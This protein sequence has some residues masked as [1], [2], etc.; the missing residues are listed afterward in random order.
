[1]TP[2][3]FLRTS[4]AVLTA[5][6]LSLP[7][8]AAAEIAGVSTLT[9]PAAERG[10]DLDVT[11]WYPAGSGGTATSLGDSIFFQGTESLRDA[12]VAE[13][14]FPLILLSHGAGLGGRPEAAAWLAA[15]L[16]AR[17]FVVAAPRHPGNTGPD[18]SAA[19]TLKLWLRPA[20]L[21]ATLDAVA[22]D[23]EFGPHLDTR[24]TGVLGLSMG[25]NSALLMTGARLDPERLAGYCDAPERNLSLCAWVRQ[26]GV[27]LHALD[28]EEAGGDRGDPR[29][30]FAMALD[31]APADIFDPAS[32]GGI[33][34]GVALI[35]LGALADSPDTVHADAIA[36]A[37]PDA[38]HRVIEG[39]S[40]D[41]MFPLCKPGAAEIALDEG[42]EDPICSDPGGRTRAEIHREILDLVAATFGRALQEAD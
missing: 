13:G 34:I 35:N 14:P 2:I 42:I 20:D 19:E 37:I 7:L 8:A 17:G 9:A 5:L 24:R 6:A 30:T 31:P 10:T 29:V 41:A 22:S 38:T 12:E 18:R 3:R 28:R 11:V 36:A 4:G 40:H 23:P 21:S 15:P 27:D 33:G 39:A 32:F 26:S 25:G 16:A 1:M